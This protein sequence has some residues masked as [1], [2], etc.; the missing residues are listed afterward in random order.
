MQW[1]LWLTWGRSYLLLAGSFQSL[2][3]Q[4]YPLIFVYLRATQYVFFFHKLANWS[5]LLGNQKSTNNNNFP[6]KSTCGLPLVGVLVD[7]ASFSR[8]SS[9]LGDWNQVSHVADRR[10]ALWATSE[11][12]IIRILVT[13]VLTVIIFFF[14]SHTSNSYCLPVMN[15]VLGTI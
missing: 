2:T 9:R 4:P 5:A 6:G 14:Q 11:A 13:E 10:F 12:P 7:F 15:Y 1:Y 3:I 8:G